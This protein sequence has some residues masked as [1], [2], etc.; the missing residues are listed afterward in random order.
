MNINNSIG[1]IGQKNLQT[2]KTYETTNANGDSFKSL[3][4]AGTQAKASTA[5]V[6]PVRT[7]RIQISHSTLA[8]SNNLELSNLKSKIV[9]DLKAETRAEKLERISTQIERKEYK[10]DP[11]ELAEIMFRV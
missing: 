6:A 11:Y 9:T 1:S 7:D 3:L 4:A 10:V 5:S 8:P 2:K